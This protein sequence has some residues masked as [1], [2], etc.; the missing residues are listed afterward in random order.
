MAQDGTNKRG[1]SPGNSFSIGDIETINT[2][3][4]N[5]MLRFPLTAL[6]SGRNGLSAGLNLYYNSK[7]YDTET[8]WFA[9]PN[10]SCEMVGDEGSAIMVCPYYQK[11]VLKESPRGGWRFGTMYSIELLDRH[12]QFNNVPQ[13]LKPQC[14]NLNWQA[15]N[16]GYYEM[17][18]RYK[19]MLHF[20]DGSSHEMRPNGWSDGN[21]NDPLG[22]WFDIR[23]DGFW[24][25]CHNNQWVQNTIT[26]YSIDGSFLRLDVQHDGNTAGAW[27]DNP[28]TLYFPDGSK[29]TNNQPNNEPQRFYDR[30]NNYVELLG[31]EIRDQFNRSIS[32][33][34]SQGFGETL[35]W[36][37]QWKT[38]SVLK[39]YWP[40]AQSLN[41]PPDVQQP[42]P[43]G[44]PRLVIDTIT[45]PAQA[46]GLTYQFHYN[47]PDHVPGQP[48]VPS[49]GWGEISGITLPSGAQV[50]YAWAQDGTPVANFTPDILQNAPTSKVLSYDQEY[51][52]TV[53]PAPDEIWTYDINPGGGSSVTAPDG[54]V[55]TTGFIDPSAASWNAG[56]NL[57]TIGPDG[58]K[59]E[60]IWDRNNLATNASANPYPKIV[61]TS[62]KSGSTYVKTAIKDFKYDKNGNVTRVAEYDWV[63]YGD[64][65]RSSGMPTG[66]PAVAPT[67]VTVNTYFNSTPAA[68]QL[69]GS[70]TNVYWSSGSPRVKNAVASTE[71]RKVLPGGAEVVVSRSEYTYDNPSVPGNV[72]QV[73]SWDST[74]GSYS[75]PLT[76][77]NSLSATTQYNQYGMPTLITDAR[78]LKTH[79]TYGPIGTATDLYPT[80]IKTAYQTAQERTET[81]EYNL[82]T[83]LVTRVTDVDNDVST[84]TTFDVL[85]RP[86]LI[87]SAQGKPEEYRTAY[88]YS[89]VL[90]RVI[91]RADLNTLGDGKLVSIQ[92]FDQLGRVRL[93]RQLEDASS[94]TAADETTGIK[95]Q[96]RYRFSGSNSYVLVSNAYRAATSAAASSEPT[97]GWARSKSD[98][99]GKVIEVQTFGGA[100]LP[101]PWGS[102]STGT[103][104]VT[105]AYDANVTTVSD[106]TQKQRR[107]II[108]GLSRLIRVDE[109]NA[110]GILG[111]VAAPNQ[112]T[113][114][115]YDVMSNL[116]RVTQSDATTTQQRDFVYSSLSLLIQAQN[117]EGGTADYKYDES[118]NLIVRKDARGVSTHYSYDSLNRITRRWYNGS[119]SLSN[120]VHNQ[121][122][123]PSGVGQTDEVKF[124]YDAQSLTGAPAG[125]SRGT[126]IGRLVAQTYGVGTNGDYFTYDNLGRVTRKYQQTGTKDY[127][128]E[129]TYNRAG[130]II[131]LKYPS[132]R[133]VNHTYDPAGRLNVVDGNLGGSQRTYSTGIIYSPS[134]GMTKEQ[135]GTNTAVYNKLFYNSRG[136]LAE[137]RASTSYNGPTDYSADRGAIVNYYS[138]N[139]TTAI[140]SGQSMPDNSGNLRKQEIHIPSQTMRYQE[141]DYDSLNRLKRVHEYTGNTA[142]DWQQEFDYD[143]WGNRTIN[144]TGTWIGNQNNPQNPLLNEMQF[145][146][147]ILASTNRLQAPGDQALPE[148]QKRMRYDAVGNLTN[149]TYT[150]AGNRTYDGENKITSA[151]GGNNQAQLYGYDPSG[152]R[153]KRTV[154]GVE[155]WQVYGF[156]GEL[157]AEYP[158][159]GELPNPQKEYGYRNGQLLLT[160]EAGSGGGAQNVNWTNAVG[161]SISSNNLTRTMAGDGWSTGA[162]SSQMIASGDGYAEFTVTETNKRRS[163][164]LT[165]N[166]SVTSFQYISYGMHIAE[167]GQITIHEGLGVYG[168]FGT[169]TTGDKLRVS[170][171]GGVVKYRKNG[172]L[173]RTSTLAPTYPLFAGAS[174]YSN[175]GTVTA[176][177]ITSGL[178]SAVW[179]NAVGVSISNNNLTRTMAGDGWSTGAISSQ[180]IASGDGYA[181]FTVTETNKRRSF[182]LTSNTSVTAYQHISYGMHIAEDGQITIHEGLGVYGVFG[183]YTAGDKLRV[184]IEGGVV[185]YRKNGTL[186]RTST[187]PPTYPLY[188]GGSIYSNAGTVTNAVLTSG[189]IGSATNF[190][191]LVTDHL[192]TPRMI[193]DQTGELANMTRH[194]Y[195]PFGEEIFAPTGGRST[196]MGYAG[197]DGVRQQFTAYERDVETGLDY[198]NARY[199]ANTQG[200]FTSPDPMLS[201]GKPPEPQSWNRYAYVLNNPLVYVDPSGL[202]W[203]YQDGTNGNGERVR[204]FMWFDGD[205]VDEGWDPYYSS[206]YVA[207]DEVLW[208]DSGSSESL[209]IARS[210]FSEEEYAS[211]LGAQG[212]DCTAFSDQQR[213]IVNREIADQVGRGWRYG[214]MKGIAGMAGGLAGSFGS[215]LNFTFGA[216]ARQANRLPPVLFHYTDEASAGLIQSSQ[217][218]RPGGQLFMTNNGGLTPLQAQLELSLPQSNTAR[219]LFAVDTQT[220]SGL[221]L[222][223]SGR[224]TGNVFSRPG[225]GFEFQFGSGTTVPQGSFTRFRF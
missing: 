37:I 193:F 109:P 211:L 116:T 156:G 181:E 38:I 13:E 165:S 153:I 172:T 201:S 164:G 39:N 127:K 183:T 154:N 202:I 67:R 31:A 150:G 194:D 93:S 47:A 1:F 12:D 52:G 65:P 58:T 147:N 190:R 25:D 213:N 218:G 62:I 167:D 9:D 21:F 80:Q 41:C 136:Q 115:T 131:Q 163:F 54:G 78:G 160:A 108:D 86:T 45:T 210:N 82:A 158:A 203:G 51:D 40:C 79:M 205:Q 16:P 215:G 120:T 34:T 53:T 94:Q 123:L 199:F 125:Y 43:Y 7:L 57:V 92:H 209:R 73:R 55:T 11:S 84:A 114:Y 122:V 214:L 221:N 155:T 49:L 87:T 130:A 4:G 223:R 32:T 206:H 90:R 110:S 185:K 169:Y 217:L 195:L 225:G 200:R 69:A 2:T 140:C 61:F 44:Y 98:N 50:N 143:R 197:G 107:S 204:T 145:D 186:L 162:I 106:Q 144:A 27:L 219:A 24:H 141:Y 191:W 212:L 17:R 64:V 96:T 198:S 83:G 28:W 139:C 146:A 171:E 137:I 113:H 97:M 6:P 29:V 135:F 95:V 105:T 15:Y 126:A 14:L 184:S 10:G 72:T 111:D 42:E 20:P 133:I 74:K 161:V 176:A 220:L 142:L 75:N 132:E 196:A 178:H 85:G 5:L 36:T 48:L 188:A 187:L 77:G 70:N 68:S 35:V 174:I 19:L 101:A 66:V 99:A 168:V 192:G 63:N 23:P 124:Y 224:V 208:L 60:T 76:T 26:Y 103:G 30:N 134:G 189:T 157:L 121:P 100:S 159:N 71:I 152:Q 207:R 88:E 104:T 151:W 56:L 128:V 89:D 91:S 166:T 182:G 175:A 173:L 3:N 112:P 138:T 18:Y 59:T 222:V 119:D 149:D 81:R 46:G 117:P 102:N 216:T 170:I 180:S 8:Q 22:D 179:T 33:V 148:N 177:V 118:G 129:A